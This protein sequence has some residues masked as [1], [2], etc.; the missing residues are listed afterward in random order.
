MIMDRRYR[1]EGLGYEIKT[2]E[3]VAAGRR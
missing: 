1:I 2:R 3:N